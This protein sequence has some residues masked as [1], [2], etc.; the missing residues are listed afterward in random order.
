MEM[1]EKENCTKTHFSI[2]LKGKKT[3]ENLTI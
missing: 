1:V 3:T 2:I